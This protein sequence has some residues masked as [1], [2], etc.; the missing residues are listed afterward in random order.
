MSD[1]QFHT[2]YW[3]SL[4]ALLWASSRRAS[5]PSCSP[6]GATTRGSRPSWTCPRARPSG[7]STRPTW[8]GPRRPS[9]RWPAS[10]GTCPCRS[11]MRHRRGGGR[12]TPQAHRRRRQGGRLHPRRRRSGRRGQGG[13]P[14]R[15]DQDGQGVRRLLG[16]QRTGRG[17]SLAE[18][19]DPGL[20]DD[21]GRGAAGAGGGAAERAA[22]GGLGGERAAR[23][24]GAAAGGAAGADR[25]STGAA[26]ARP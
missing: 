18:S 13:E 20:R 4:K 25:M 21:R 3:P 7:C 5:Y 2:F 14:A 23:A 22:A 12:A 16:S 15:H 19:G 10:R 9:A 1:E 8:P 24:A 26:A 11:C 17:D 6:R